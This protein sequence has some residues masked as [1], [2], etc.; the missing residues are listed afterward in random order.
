VVHHIVAFVTLFEAYLAIDPDFDLWN[1]FFRVWCPH[2][3][4]AEQTISG[5]MPIHVESGH[6]VEPYP[7]IPMPRSMKGWRKKWFY[8]RNYASA[9]LP[10]FTGSRPVPL[11]SCGDGVAMKYLD[12]LQPLCEAF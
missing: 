6:G 8:L 10:M 1:Y 11:P 9:V 2:D 3:P 5:G 7:K 12:K 4:K